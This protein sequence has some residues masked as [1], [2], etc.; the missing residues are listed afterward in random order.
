MD[1][2][3][4]I[5]KEESE[6]TSRASIVAAMVR[7]RNYQDRK[8][9]N[10]PHTVGEWLLIMESELAEAKRGWTEEGGDRRALEE[11][12]Q[13][14]AVAMACMEQYGIREEH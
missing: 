9:G 3:D 11:I 6:K 5:S 14:A 12:L 4:E 10:R 7:E 13:I 2:K 8:W 1:K